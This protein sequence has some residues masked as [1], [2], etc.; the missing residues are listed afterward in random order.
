MP[1]TPASDAIH[2]VLYQ[3]DPFRRGIVH[4][5]CA[6][7]SVKE[8]FT[9]LQGVTEESCDPWTT[10]AQTANGKGFTTQ[11]IFEWMFNALVFVAMAVGAYLALAAVLRL[12]D[13]EFA[14]FSKGFGKVIAVY[15]RSLKEKTTALRNSIAT[16][17]N[18]RAYIQQQL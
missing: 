12:Y 8:S 3:N 13:V 18:P 11:K 5:P 16:A 6:I 17:S 9:D 1:V 10:W 14:D 15:F 4:K 2:A 7:G